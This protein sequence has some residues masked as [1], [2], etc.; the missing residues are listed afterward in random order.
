MSFS[1]FNSKESS[2]YTHYT[3]TL[4][5]RWKDRKRGGT[6]MM[7]RVWVLPFEC[8]W[9]YLYTFCTCMSAHALVMHN[10]Q[11]NQNNPLNH[12]PWAKEYHGQTKTIAKEKHRVFIEGS[13]FECEREIYYLNS[14]GFESNV[15]PFSL[16]V[17][18]II[19]MIKLFSGKF[20]SGC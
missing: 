9:W 15:H 13:F 16:H 14:F 17:I 18:V 8:A 20:I 2:T 19:A 5:S 10:L 4:L 3:D 6:S 11:R 1:V 12:M 7:M